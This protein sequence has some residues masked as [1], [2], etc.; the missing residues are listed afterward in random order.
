M[1]DD[2]PVEPHIYGLAMSPDGRFLAF[3]T[4]DTGQMPDGT[5]ATGNW[6]SVYSINSTGALSP[7]DGFPHAINLPTPSWIQQVLFDR[8]GNYLLYRSA[9]GIRRFAF[10][11]G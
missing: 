9:T 5:T 2:F 1:G 6:I 4:D 10:H 11:A 3:P 8:T 7:A